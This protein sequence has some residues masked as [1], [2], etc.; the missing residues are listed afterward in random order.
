MITLTVSAYLTHDFCVNSYFL[1]Y[2]RRLRRSGFSAARKVGSALHDAIECLGKGEGELAALKAIEEQ[3]KDAPS[4]IYL[5]KARVM[6]EG[7]LKASH[8][9]TKDFYKN[10]YE[11]KTDL[12][13]GFNL[14]GKCDG[15][16][17]YTR[18]GKEEPELFLYELKTTSDTLKVYEDILVQTPQIHAYNMILHKMGIDTAGTI[19][20]VI[21]KPLKSEL[22]KAEKEAQDWDAYRQRIAMEYQKEPERMILSKIVDRD[23]KREADALDHFHRMADDIES[24]MDASLEVT[25]DNFRKQPTT[26][27]KGPWGWCEFKP[28]CW[29][30]PDHEDLYYI[31]EEHEELSNDQGTTNG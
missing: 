31:G 15:L 25:R 14:R 13:P 6:L 26:N 23:Y 18:E 28:W 9:L 30:E 7:Y 1:R 24:R 22:R 3:L 21:K 29:R 11:I 2:L 12:R 4:P 17:W 20:E 16:A 8:V 27:C 10:E 5:A 19:I